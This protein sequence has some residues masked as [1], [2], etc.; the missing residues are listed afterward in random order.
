M[1]IEI[2][3][4]SYHANPYSAHFSLVD[5][6]G[7]YQMCIPTSDNYAQPAINYMFN[8]PPRSLSNARNLA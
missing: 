3:D 5:G 4:Y 6:L 1:Q 8:N 2:C 7:G